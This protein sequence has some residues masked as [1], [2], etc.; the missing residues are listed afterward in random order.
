M[1]KEEI[2]KEF[3]SSVNQLQ[4]SFT[5]IIDKLLLSTLMHPSRIN[6]S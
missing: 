1:E 2:Q 5:Q 3:H 6:S 4:Q